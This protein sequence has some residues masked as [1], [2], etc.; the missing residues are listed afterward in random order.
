MTSHTL[1]IITEDVKTNQTV[2]DEHWENQR[3]YSCHADVLLFGAFSINTII[4]EI[5]HWLQLLACEGCQQQLYLWL[6]NIREQLIMHVCV[7]EAYREMWASCCLLRDAVVLYPQRRFSGKMLPS[8]SLCTDYT[9]LGTTI[10]SW[11]ALALRGQKSF[12]ICWITFRPAQS[13]VN[14]DAFKTNSS[15]LSARMPQTQAAG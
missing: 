1:L 8:V 6:L 5:T 10:T 15:P 11:L 12:S 3:S 2:W 14:W 9:H 4:Q 7:L 13:T